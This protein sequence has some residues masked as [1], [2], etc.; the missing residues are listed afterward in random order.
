LLMGYVLWF[1]FA[2]TM[3][4]RTLNIFNPEAV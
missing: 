2:I 3:Y 4:R 1:G